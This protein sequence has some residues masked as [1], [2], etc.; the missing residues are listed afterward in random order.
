MKT[1]IITEQNFEAAASLRDQELKLRA[2]YDEEK[3][4]WE[5][6]K[7]LENNDFLSIFKDFFQFVNRIKLYVNTHGFGSQK[8][9]RVL[10]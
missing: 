9:V 4:E 1:T 3:S 6:R 10:L 2:K 5:K 8:V 7:S